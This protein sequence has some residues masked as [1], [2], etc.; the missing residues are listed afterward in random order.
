MWI[1]LDLPLLGEFGFPAI[2]FHECLC[3]VGIVRESASFP[4]NPYQVF[5]LFIVFGSDGTGTTFNEV[6]RNSINIQTFEN[7]LVIVH[8]LAGEFFLDKSLSGDK[9]E[10]CVHWC[11]KRCSKV[12]DSANSLFMGRVCCVRH[13]C[14]E[15]RNCKT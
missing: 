3:V 6:V 11:S 2:V 5:D 9:I 10:T 15:M 1:H 14:E 4:S 8:H 13:R 12:L 7:G